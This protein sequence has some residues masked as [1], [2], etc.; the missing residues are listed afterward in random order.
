M[1]II[2]Q[3]LTIN[4]EISDNF[5]NDDTLPKGFLEAIDKFLEIE[6]TGTYSEDSKDKMYEQILKGLFDK[7]NEDEKKELVKWCKEYNANA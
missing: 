2:I 1:N 3:I 4:R 7:L 5:H 6:D